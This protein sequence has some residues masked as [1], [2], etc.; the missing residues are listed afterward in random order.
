MK[1]PYKLSYPRPYY[2]IVL[3][4]PEGTQRSPIVEPFPQCQGHLAESYHRS[5][6][7]HGEETFISPTPVGSCVVYTLERG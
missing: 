4:F 2:F 1:Y 3:T 5:T 6:V 7:T